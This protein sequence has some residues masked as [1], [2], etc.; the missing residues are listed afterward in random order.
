MS[1]I[2]NDDIIYARLSVVLSKSSKNAIVLRRGPSKHVGVFGWDRNTDKFTLTQWLK[3]R[4]YEDCCEISPDGKYWIYFGLNG[5][6]HTETK[7]RWTAIAKY[8]WLK[9]LNLYSDYNCY[10]CGGG[11]FISDNSFSIYNPY[12]TAL[13]EKLKFTRK[14]IHPSKQETIWEDRLK[15]YGW[16]FG[17]GTI[18]KNLGCGWILKK[19]YSI[20]DHDYRLVKDEKVIEHPEWQWA[21]WLDDTL[22]Y[23]EKGCLFRQK[24]DPYGKLMEPILLHDFNDYKFQVLEAP[25]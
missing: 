9:A 7:G 15:F 11:F 4:I 22:A 13:R 6:E 21:D 12:T 8:P 1:D 17:D 14:D 10:H 20:D 16:E 3:G 18:Y 19:G 24:I 23:S 2:C 5:K 25:Y